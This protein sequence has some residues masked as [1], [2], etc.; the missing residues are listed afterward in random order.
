MESKN[1]RQVSVPVSAWIK[2]RASNNTITKYNRQ[3]QTPTDAEDGQEDNVDEQFS[4]GRPDGQLLVVLDLLRLPG[5]PQGCTQT[6]F[7]HPTTSKRWS[8]YTSNVTNY[9]TVNIYEYDY[10]KNKCN[11]LRLLLHI[12]VITSMISFKNIMDIMK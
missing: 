8:D 6:S 11:Q 9:K 7:H 2:T 4:Q 1:R 12:I 5:C 10:F 3:R